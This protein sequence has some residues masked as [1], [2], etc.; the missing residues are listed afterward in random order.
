M[1]EVKD[2]EQ[3]D[4]PQAVSAPEETAQTA[5]AAESPRKGLKEKWSSMPLSLIHI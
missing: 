2:L 5:P 3:N 4:L 1:A